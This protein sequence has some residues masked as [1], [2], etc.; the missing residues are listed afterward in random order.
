MSVKRPQASP[1]RIGHVA[2]LLTAVLERE[3]A[4]AD[5]TISRFFAERRYLGSHDRGFIAD[6]VY[7]ALR[8]L[9]RYRALL[10]PPPLQ[11]P[12][13]PEQ[14]RRGS[15]PSDEQ[16]PSISA[17][18]ATA[19]VAMMVETHRNADVEA[20]ARGL[21]LS[22]ETVRAIAS[23]VREL[24]A[25]IEALDEPM[26]S[27]M[28]HALPTWFVARLQ[29]QLGFEEA[30]TVL[31]SLNHQAP[32]VL[33]ANTLRADR[34][35]LIERLRRR[36]IDA[37]AGHW[38]PQSVVLRRR[39]NANAIP[40]FKQGYFEL[41]D[42][43]SQ[44][45]SVALDPWPTW[46]VLDAC[47]GAGGKSLHLAAI[48]KGRGEVIAHDLN[49]RRL[50]M[51]RPRLKRS[52]AQNIRVVSHDEFV[53]RSPSIIGACD[54]VMIDAPCTGTGVLR[55]NPGAR[56]SLEEEM[57]ERIVMQ[58]R[59]II[60]DY[61]RFVK[62]GGLLLYATC[63][64]LREENEDQVEAFLGRSGEFEQIPTP[65]PDALQSVDG[66]LRTWPHLHGA[67]GFYGALM[68]RVG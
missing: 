24:P 27:A 2:E 32:I 48:M 43:G 26:R 30:G 33:R 54:A 58:Q 51:I 36:G 56:L 67:D 9:P 37:A 57:L 28:L 12:S 60:D 61:A 47:A 31:A 15:S 46:R 63:S 10:A 53:S 38:A 17:E 6:A 45:L 68:R 1:F 25:R 22:R 23:R 5:L 50:A 29:H 14:S 55:R 59:E 11:P 18:A 42:E 39:M 13:S 7:D 65:A 66:A 49:A 41:Q 8:A 20:T 52:G 40:E 35:E 21:Q 64:L 4:P 44:L 16:S 34:E 3:T 62:P 19:V